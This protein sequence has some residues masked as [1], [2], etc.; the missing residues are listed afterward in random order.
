MRKERVRDLTK[1][2][3]LF[4]LARF[5]LIPVLWVWAFKGYSVYLGIG[6]IIA[7]LTDAFDGVIARR[8]NMVTKFGSQFDSIADHILGTSAIIWLLML[9]PAVYHENKVLFL[10]AILLYPAGMLVGLLKFKRFANLHLYSGKLYGGLQIIFISHAFL[11]EGYSRLLFLIMV[12]VFIFSRIETLILLLTRDR[13]DEHMGSV[14][15]VYWRERKLTKGAN[16]E[17]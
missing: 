2:P 16:E 10:T 12:S 1:L 6:L 7:G 17:S 13:V 3:N 4:T 5:L 11:F 8:L 15:Q 9:E 14:I